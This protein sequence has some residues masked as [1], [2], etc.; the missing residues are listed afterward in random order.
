MN[1][2][3]V[4][5]L[6]PT[7]DR[8][9]FVPIA[10]DTFLRQD[11]GPRELVVLDDG[12]DPICDLL[13]DDRRIRYFRTEG[14]RTLGEKRNEV[15]GLARGDIFVHWDDDDWSAP[16]R[17]S[18]Q[19]RELQRHDADVCGLNRL[20]FYEPE[21]D[22]AWLYH[23]RGSRTS[24]VAGSTLCYWRRAWEAH[25]FPDVNE[26]E[27]TLWIAWMVGAR[28]LPLSRAEFF[29]ARI[30]RANTSPKHTGG[31]WWTRRD[32]AT[33]REI[34]GSDL[35]RFGVSP[36]LPMPLASC[37]LVT[38]GRRSFFELAVECYL[39][40]DYPRKELVVIDD[41]PQDIEDI[42]SDVLDVQ[43]YHV[44]NRSSLGAKRNLGCA[45]AKGDVLVQWDDDDWY[46]SGRLSRQVA[47]VAD[48]RADI[49]ALEARWIAELPGGDFWTVSPKLHRRMFYC[50]VHG[51]TLAFSRAVWMSGARYPEDRW[52]GEDAAFLHSALS[53][54]QR[55]QRI[56]NDELFVYMRHSAN[57]WSFPVGNYLDPR[58]WG[59][60]SAPQAILPVL[61]ARYQNAAR[62]LNR[63]VS[64]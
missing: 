6:M 18:Y 3:L 22:L 52:P 46:G 48:G 43:Y 2:P 1:E 8:R 4:S 51:G 27:D 36:P 16:W 45:A 20:W 30:H 5:C 14:G 24:W 42:L 11:Y 39:T 10:I 33:V 25:P 28:I 34:L 49:T 60:T 35:P 63:K 21:C 54:G 13:P 32:S 41:G 62:T 12:A 47:P 57:T 56:A 7:A 50:D 23:Y 59:R 64:G 37:I 58:G 17:L 55:L 26:G 31:P 19:V 15:C 40:Q 38:G 53:K 61:L 29:I 9:S 44:S